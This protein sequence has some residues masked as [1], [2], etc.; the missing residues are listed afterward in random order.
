MGAMVGIDPSSDGLRRAASLGVPTTAEG[1]DGL[2][3]MDGFDEIDIVFDATSAG[4]TCQ[5]AALAAGTARSSS[6][7]PRRRSAPTSSR[8]VNLE[9]HPTASPNVNMVTCG[10]QATIPIVAA[11]PA[12]PPSPTPRS[13]RRSRRSRPAPAP[14]PTSTSSPRPPRRPSRRWAAPQ[15]GKAIII[16]NPAEPPLIMRDTVFC[17]IGDADHD[18]I[19]ASIEAMVAKVQ[20]YVPGYRLK[21]EV[22]FTPIPPDEPVHT[23]CPRAPR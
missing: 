1:V 11:S 5:R 2:L 18:A 4:A 22:Q 10:G 6:T 19:R 16:L 7:S 8:P 13:S 15:R 12:S 9:E 21:Q 17:L 14:A 20:E 23:R 3:A